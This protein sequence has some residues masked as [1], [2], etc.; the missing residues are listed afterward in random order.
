MGPSQGRN[1][2]EG[3]V[4]MGRGMTDRTVHVQGMEGWDGVGITRTMSVRQPTY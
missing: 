3:E 1:V 4:I 2:D